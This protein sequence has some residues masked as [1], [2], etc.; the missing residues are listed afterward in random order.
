MNKLP[1]EGTIATLETMYQVRDQ[2]RAQIQALETRLLIWM[3]DNQV[4]SVEGKRLRLT[5]Q[6]EIKEYKV[7]ASRFERIPLK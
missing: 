6:K 1:P 2:V 3:T 5:L 7:S 4:D